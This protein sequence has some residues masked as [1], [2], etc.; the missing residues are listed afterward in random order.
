M[1]SN[2]STVRKKYYDDLVKRLEKTGEEHPVPYKSGTEYTQLPVYEIPIGE[3][4][5]TGLRF[6]LDNSRII[7]Y[8]MAEEEKRGRSLDPGKPETAGIHKRDPSK[9]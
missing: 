3:D 9:R 4:F 6:N 7:K 1:S 8:V 2:V 5:K